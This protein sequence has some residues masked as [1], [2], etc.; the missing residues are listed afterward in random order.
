[1]SDEPSRTVVLPR[2]QVQRYGWRPDLPDFRDLL[3]TD[4]PAL[5]PVPTT[6]RKFSLRDREPEPA[7]DQ[8]NLGSCTGNGCAFVWQFE[9]AAQNRVHERPS[10]L[11]IYYYERF[12]EGDVA[13]DSG[14]M[15]RD[16]MKVLA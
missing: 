14:A 9:A 15:I 5:P 1:M 16:G 2:R 6:V 10:R 3:L 12:I 4:E 8:G 13:T 11:F 7:W